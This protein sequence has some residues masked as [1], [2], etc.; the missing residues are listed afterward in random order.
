MPGRRREGNLRLNSPSIVNIRGFG[1]RARAGILAALATLLAVGLWLV[2]APGAGAAA[3]DVRLAGLDC[4]GNPE[5]VEIKNSGD[6]GQDLTGWKLLSDPN[7]SFDLTPVGT[8]PAGGSVFVE[9][10][11]G[12][13]ATFTWSQSPVFRDNDA[14]DYVRLVD[15]AG[16]TKSELRCAQPTPTPA[17]AAPTPTPTV[18]PGQVPNGGGPPGTP[19]ELI[20]PMTLIYAGGSVVAATAGIALSWLGVGL[21]LDRRRTRRRAAQAPAEAPVEPAQRELPLTPAATSARGLSLPNRN[22]AQPLVLALIV[23]LAAAVLVAFLVQSEGSSR[24]R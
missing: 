7:E 5:V 24:R 13:Q 17:T 20:S 1:E 18:G 15:S 2:G 16:Q 4:T 21:G 11:P 10:G 23:A 19:D 22:A 3:S 9:S 14:S 12:A 6:A 8:I